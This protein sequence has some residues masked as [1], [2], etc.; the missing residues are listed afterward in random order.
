MRLS[1]LRHFGCFVD[2][3]RLGRLRERV[4]EHWQRA[5]R[6]AGFRM[7]PRL[8]NRA[9]HTAKSCLVPLPSL[10]LTPS[11]VQS[12]RMGLFAAFSFLEGLS[13]GPAINMV[14][15]TYP[16]VV[17]MAFF[18]TLTIFASFSAAALVAKRRSMLYL[19]GACDH[20]KKTAVECLADLRILFHW[21]DGLDL[22]EFWLCYLRSRCMVVSAGDILWPHPLLSLHPG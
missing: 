2:G 5:D 3:L 12:K 6:F 4:G 10:F 13:I 9:A 16:S 8:E 18:T 21:T 1:G 17:L 14:L 11:V 7:P 20:G 22:L 15:D 19:T